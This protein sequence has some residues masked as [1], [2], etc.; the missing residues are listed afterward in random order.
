MAI[1]E[2]EEAVFVNIVGDIKPAE[3][4]RIGRALHIHSMDAPLEVQVEGDAK[5]TVKEGE[6]KQ[7]DD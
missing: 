1:E 7:E 6:A 4:A 3:I 2:D 5:V